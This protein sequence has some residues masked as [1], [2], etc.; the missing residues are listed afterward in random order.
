MRSFCR[1][2]WFAAVGW[3]LLTAWLCCGCRDVRAQGI[4]TGA[5][6]GLV[7]DSDGNG[8]SRAGVTVLSRDSGEEVRAV[9]LRD[10]SFTM[11][12]LAPGDYLLR[13]EGTGRGTT[14]SVAPGETLEVKATVTGSGLR[15]ST[16]GGPAFSAVD[17][18]ESSGSS[19]V[20]GVS[21]TQ[22]FGAVPLGSGSDAVVNPDEDADSA[23]RTTGASHGLGRGRHA[24]VD[25]LYAAG[26]VREFRVGADGYSAQVGGAGN[27]LSAVTRQGGEALHGSAFFHVR[28][29]ALAASDPLAIAT[30]YADGI[31]TSGEVKPHD[32]RES[33]GGTLGGA[34]GRLRLFDA[35]DLERR[36]FPA[37]S[38]PQD[39]NFYNLSTIQRDLLAN[40]GVSDPAINA[41]LNY[42][43]SLTGETPRRAD[44]EINFVRADWHLRPAFGV[45]AEYNLVRW[46][47]PAGLIDAPVVAR[48]RASLGNAQG[49]VDEL[50]GRMTLERSSRT[51]HQVRLAWIRDLQFETPQT[52]LAQEPAIGPNGTAPEVN[53]GPKGLLFGTPAGL[54]QLAYPDEQ[55]M[56]VGD[57]A[58]LLRGHQ[59]IQFGGTFGYVHDRIAT[60]ANAAGTFRYDSDDLKGYAGGLVDF[61]TDQTFNANAPTNGGCPRISAADHLSCFRS[62][63][64]SFGEQVISFATQDWAGFVEDT[65][66]PLPGLMLHGGLRY[67][68]LFLPLPQSPNA[69]LDALFGAR[70]ATS[71]LPEDR[72]NFGP[73]LSASF[74]PFGHGRG[75]VKLGYGIFFGRV[76]GATIAAA[77]S[78]TGLASSTTKIR[79]RPS[80]ETVCPQSPTTG[81]GYPCSFVGAPPGVAAL[82]TS[83][84][85]F[86]RRFRTPVVQQGSFFLEHEIGRR[87]SI[88]VGAVI[89]E[90]RQLPSS[91]DIN[92]VPSAATKEFQLQG[93][94]GR[95]GV[96]DGETFVVPVY[97]AR[98]SPAFGPVTDIVSHVNASYNAL[99]ARVSS[100]AGRSL[101]VSAHYSWSKAIDFGQ[102]ASAIPR[103]NGQF[104]PF[105]NGYDKSLSSLNFPQAL[106][107]E[108]VWTPSGEAAGRHLRRAASG[109]TVSAIEVARSGRPYSYDLSGGTYLPG[110]H[111]SLNGSGG[112][113]YLPTVGRNTLRLPSTL[114]T[115]LR[116]AR[117]FKAWRSAEG[118]ATVEVFNLLNHQ[119]ITSVNQ[120]AYLVEGEANGVTPLVFQNA[121]AIAAEGLNTT[122]FGTPI[123]T[124]SSLNR[125]REM[126][127]SLRIA[128]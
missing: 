45:G 10:G 98:V 37:I 63:T 91:T 70:G 94:N 122:P 1:P 107:A 65:W 124:G 35:V 16:T 108:A 123:G 109:W 106:H 46:R 2:E 86:D 38:S 12:P 17:P 72:N 84:V 11:A 93:G 40:R 29:S 61:I 76:P 52:P 105:A 42:L 113:L 26:S 128:F 79:I 102:A 73:R 96:R 121:D 22:G 47:S 117:A 81:F 92:I 80:V 68:Y 120:R 67:E 55:R 127:L 3:L 83:S 64:E 110:G 44:Q 69:A 111:E 90:D 85:V 104:D 14:V 49:S 71:V 75:L 125:A 59:L 6:H 31:V 9:A 51:T 118:L 58:T 13:F 32:L 89:N 87:S 28:S 82:T 33:F 34:L 7:V 20:D 119:S 101:L 95:P 88:E 114:K 115:D 60:L 5:I 50:V 4:A 56:E 43:S 126:Q 25:Y 24:G 99:V 77:L 8:L 18:D 39:P 15:A 41:A 27:V 23:E 54:S 53:I 48:G 97:T 103:T 19:T 36:G 30:S 74:E 78:D 21:G 66:R 57:T 112:A 116:I 100:R 62:F